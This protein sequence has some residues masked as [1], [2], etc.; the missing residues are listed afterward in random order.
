[1]I[2]LHHPSHGVK[3]AYSDTEAAIDKRNGWKEQETSIPPDIEASNVKEAGKEA[4]KGTVE[5]NRKRKCKDT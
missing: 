2:Y 3:I 4:P 5:T 1:M